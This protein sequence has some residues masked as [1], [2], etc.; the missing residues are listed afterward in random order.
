MSDDSLSD[1]DKTLFRQMMGAV[2]PLGKS[3]KIDLPTPKPRTKPVRRERITTSKTAPIADTIY[4]SDYY[5]EEVQANTILSYSSHSIPNKRLRE[6]KNGLIPWQSRLDLHGLKSDAARGA[7]LNF[8]LQQSSFEHRCL[9]II[10]GKGSPKGEAPV[11]KNLV[12]HWLPQFPQVLAFHSALS[13]DGG[14]GALYVLLK[15]Q[16]EEKN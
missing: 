6:L 14:C 13:R 9:L 4:L 12:N 11:L 2:K 5:S 7:L 16:K 8:I 10:H 15:R 1:E 3:K